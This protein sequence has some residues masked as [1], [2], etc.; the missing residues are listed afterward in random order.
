MARETMDGGHGR[1]PRARGLSGG[2]LL[3]AEPLVH[4]EAEA[5]ICDHGAKAYRE[6][7]QQERHVIL[8]D[9]TTHAGRTAA[10]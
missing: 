3:Q 9:G 5:L 8:P 10:H 6:A 7:R 4:A 1:G 2:A